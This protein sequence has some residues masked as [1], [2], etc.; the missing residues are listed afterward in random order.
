MKKKYIV[1]FLFLIVFSSTTKSQSQFNFLGPDQKEQSV[2]FNLINNLIVI[3][4][5]VNGRQLSFILD[6]G[7]NKT[8]LFN[9][10]QNDS[11]DLN[12]VR[13][14]SLQGLG[15]GKSM[16][17]L[18]SGNNTL[19]IK[20]FVG[21]NQEIY[22]LLKDRFD[23]SGR[24]GITIHGIVGYNLFK[25]A[26][27][28]INYATR[29]VFFY[30]PKFYKEKKCRKC[31]SFPL[32]FFRNKPYIDAKIQLDT[33]G[34]TV[35]DVKLLID[36]GGS[37]AIWLFEN[38]KEEIQTPIRHFDDVLG[39]G[40]SGTIYGKKSRIKQILIG[41][42]KIKDPTV[43][44]L[45]SSSTFNAR[46]FKER[47]G[48]VGG[49]I[50]KRFKVWVDYKNKKITLK[51]NGSFRG[52]FE[53][54]MSGLD[55]VYNGKVLVKEKAQT[56]FSDAYSNSV[57][58]T[59]NN[60]T[61]SLVSTYSYRFKPSYKIK[62]VLENSPAGLAGIKKNDI[63]LSINGTEVHKLTLKQLLGKFQK[64]HKRKIRMTIER[65]GVD[66]NFQFRLI[67]KI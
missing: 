22:V 66:I 67:K 40:I 1:F 4:M 64:G 19:K 20:N 33:V 37:E 62:H 47:N 44:F 21:E 45:D 65:L 30:N 7:V 9:L 31:Q 52:G 3:P 14:I 10:S 13:K 32:Q 59:V 27:V 51:K 5:E 49:N 12:D 50:L 28:Y 8:I 42:F 60:S 36:T 43:S 54:N 46:Q 57:S 25:D 26:I 15:E 58:Q 53:Y 6:T 55:V 48:S 24:M 11:I 23:V 39:E 16:D 17:A 56:T 2:R 18:I 38:S 61:I 34:N 41:S 63:I 29:R 35:T